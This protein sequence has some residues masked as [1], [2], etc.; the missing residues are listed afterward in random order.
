MLAFGV[1]VHNLLQAAVEVAV[2]VSTVMSRGLRTSLRLGVGVGDFVE[3]FGRGF[4]LPQ[5][6][7]LPPT[8][9]SHG[10]SLKARQGFLLSQV[11]ETKV[12][13]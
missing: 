3:H 8:N 7:Q 4:L 11:A 5:E 10:G 9:F 13:G 1:L 2:R 6:R 12:S